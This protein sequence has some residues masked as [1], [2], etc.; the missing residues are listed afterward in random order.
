MGCHYGSQRRTPWC[1]GVCETVQLATYVVKWK[2]IITLFSH[3]IMR[4]VARPAKRK[5]TV[6]WSSPPR[7][8]SHP[9]PP[10]SPPP[11][12]I[13][14]SGIIWLPPAYGHDDAPGQCGV[15]CPME[16]IQGFT[17]SHWKPPLGGC[18]RHIATEADIGINFC[19]ENKNTT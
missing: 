16:H 3:K 14:A 7:F 17:R 9:P 6:F 12:I 11:T 15:H 10:P 1:R 4:L 13:T 8:R 2:I 18:L 5:N 19:V